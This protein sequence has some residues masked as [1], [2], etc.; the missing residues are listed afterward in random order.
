MRPATRLVLVL[1]AAGGVPAAAFAH[2]MKVVVAVTADAVRVT[3]SYDSDDDHGGPVTVKLLDGQKRVIGEAKPDKDGF[4][5]FPRPAPGHYRVVAADEFGHRAERPFEV[6][7]GDETTMSA[8]PEQ[9][10]S[11]M[12]AVGLGVIAVLTL[13]GYWWAGRKKG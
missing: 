12:V 2:A 1:L 4:C 10:R 9:S 13:A 3:V 7:G 11:L 5:V 8:P 6:K